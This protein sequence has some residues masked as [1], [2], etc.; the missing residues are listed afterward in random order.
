VTDCMDVLEQVRVP[1]TERFI[2]LTGVKPTQRATILEWVNA[3]GYPLDGMKKATIDAILDPEDDVSVDV[4]S[5]R[6][7]P[8]VLEAMELRRSLASSSVAKL[9]RMLDCAGSDGRVRYTTQ[10]HVARTGRD[11]GRLIQ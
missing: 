2:A 3:N 6:I 9:Q 7:P 10:Y 11:G 1:M 5:D 8:N 4:L